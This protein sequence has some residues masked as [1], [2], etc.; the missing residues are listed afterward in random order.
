MTASQTDR[1]VLTCFVSAGTDTDLSPILEALRLA[2]VQTRTAD[3]IGHGERIVESCMSAIL[4]ADFVC[5]VL[6]SA[7]V[8][9]NVAFEAG[10]AAG[11]R[12]PVVV[13][14]TLAANESARVVPLTEMATIRYDHSER[15]LENLRI[16]IDAFVRNVQPSAMQIA[17]DWG[18]VERANRSRLGAPSIRGARLVR[19][20]G[21]RLASAGGYVTEAPDRGHDLT[22]EFPLLGPIGSIPIEVKTRYENPRIHRLVESQL[23]KAMRDHGA[24]LGI[25]VYNDPDDIRERLTEGLG[26]QASLF[27]D[28]G[29]GIL[30]VSAKELVGW[31]DN[32]LV[33]ELTRLRN[34][35]FHGSR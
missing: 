5:V 6:A 25:L 9:P 21:A 20:I 11:S 1:R 18:Q 13:A 7:D 23:R 27:D 12:R 22:V 29:T 4:T 35:A 8:N 14:S 10:V 30:V 3:D 17:I 19:L 16:G 33:A 24:L 26:S 34:S 31:T 15:G 28:A 32:Q 2:G